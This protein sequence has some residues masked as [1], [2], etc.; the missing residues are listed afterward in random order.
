MKWR[1]NDGN[2]EMNRATTTKVQRIPLRYSLQI[3]SRLAI[4]ESS[5]GRE[6]DNVVE[7]SRIRSFTRVKENVCYTNCAI[8]RLVDDILI[9]SISLKLTSSILLMFLVPLDLK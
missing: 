8:L 3:P 4:R 1:E 5:S 7:L 9:I 6:N 2:Q